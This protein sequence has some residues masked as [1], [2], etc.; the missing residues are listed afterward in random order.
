MRIISLNLNGL[1]SAAQKGVMEWLSTQ[2]ADVVCVQEIK[3]QAAD[4]SPSHL[5]FPSDKGPVQAW[6]HCAEKRGYSGV[7]LYS[8]HRPERVETGFGAQEFDA[9]GRLVRADFSVGTFGSSPLSVMSLYAP[10]GS[11]SEERQASKFRFMEVF[12]PRLEAWM[13]DHRS[14]GRE[15]VICGDWNIAHT[16]KDLKNWR[17]NL[18]QSGFLPQERAWMTE[19]LGGLGWVDSFRRLY[20][21]EEAQ[22]YT[23]WSN[24]GQARANNVGWRIDYTLVTPGLAERLVDARVYKDQKFS[25]HAALV[26]DFQSSHV[27]PP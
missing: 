6:L 27:T 7:G 10:S 20:P 9:E 23:W 19:V 18:K 11:A 5:S 16:E 21:E 4:L 24:R 26:V 22:G 13:R 8:P 15:Y 3:A 17:G 1:R 12:L 14:S 25:D 2:S